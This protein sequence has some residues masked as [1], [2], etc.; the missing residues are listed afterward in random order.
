MVIFGMVKNNVMTL[1]PMEETLAI[2]SANG[3]HVAMA[4]S[5]KE[6]KLIREKIVTMGTEMTTT[7]APTSAQWQSVAMAQSGMTPKLGAQNSVMMKILKTKTRAWAVK[8]LTVEMELSGRFQAQNNVMTRMTTPMITALNVRT[9]LAGTAIFLTLER[10][11]KNATTK[12][13]T[14]T[15]TARINVRRPHVVMDLSGTTL[16]LGEKNNVTTKT[17]SVQTTA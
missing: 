9:Q 3:R 5:L 4:I 17:P 7:T 13:E 12:T 11:P 14:T 1:T 15:I 16:P 10:E 2:A 6:M 8:M